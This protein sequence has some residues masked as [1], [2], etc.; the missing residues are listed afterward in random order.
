MCAV[1]E[2]ISNKNA[3]QLS[4][5]NLFNSTYRVWI[6]KVFW[7][8]TMKDDFFGLT[9]VNTRDF[10]VNEIKTETKIQSFSLTETKTKTII[11]LKTKSK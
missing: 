7:T 10:F 4:N 8:R 9:K 1:I 2:I 11:N 5:I 3:K 6:Y